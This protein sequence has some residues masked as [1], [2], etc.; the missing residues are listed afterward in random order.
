VVGQSPRTRSC[1]YP[2]AIARRSLRTSS[3]RGK[4]GNLEWMAY[5]ASTS[6]AILEARDGR[7]KSVRGGRLIVAARPTAAM[8]GAALSCLIAVIG[9]PQSGPIAT[10]PLCW[11]AHCSLVRRRQER[12]RPA[13][14][15]ASAVFN[16]AAGNATTC[17]R[18]VRWR[19]PSHR[20]P[21]S[22]VP[23][24]RSPEEH[25]LRRP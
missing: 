24:A 13:R 19:L 2:C 4:A 25:P 23:V 7:L 9:L 3:P 18:P 1:S 8:R 20:P 16:A 5:F 14:H 22:A 21:R 12:R 6:R 11:C 17:S 15:S 10:I